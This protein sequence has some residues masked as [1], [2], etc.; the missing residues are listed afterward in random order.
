MTTGACLL[1]GSPKPEDYVPTLIFGN[2]CAF[3]RVMCK[4]EE[5]A[6]S[7]SSV[8]LMAP[9]GFLNE[10]GEREIISAFG[11]TLLGILQARPH[12]AVLSVP[13]TEFRRGIFSATY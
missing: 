9:W 6:S 10:L 7:A 12:G 1:Q 8:W 4:E 13:N 2:V 5:L 11:H 3:R